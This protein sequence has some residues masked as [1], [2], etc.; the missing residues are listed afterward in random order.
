MKSS[1][2]GI[3]IICYVSSA[4]CLLLN[5]ASSYSFDSTIRVAPNVLNIQSEGTVVTV[6]TDISYFAVD[7]YSVSLNGIEISSWKADN[8]GNFVAKFPM[9][10]V[11]MEDLN[12]GNTILST[13]EGY[14][15]DGEYF[16][17]VLDILVIDVVPAGRVVFRAVL[18]AFVRSEAGSCLILPLFLGGFRRPAAGILIL[19]RLHELPFG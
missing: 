9:D 7:A 16:V 3:A 4:A 19:R 11:K 17:G 14:T 8:R 10:E 1:R 13:I 12:I 18:K 15:Y 6:H 2:T 5:P